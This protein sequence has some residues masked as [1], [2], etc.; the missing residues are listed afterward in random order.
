M[1]FSTRQ[2]RSQSPRSSWSAPTNER[3]QVHCVWLKKTIALPEVNIQFQISSTIRIAQHKY[4][5]PPPTATPAST[6]SFSLGVLASNC[7]GQAHPQE[8]FGLAHAIACHTRITKISTLFYTLFWIFSLLREPLD[9]PLPWKI[10]YFMS[11]HTLIPG[12]QNKQR[13]HVS[14]CA[15]F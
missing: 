10:G 8:H 1:L 14:G 2:S 3:L 4:L 6:R 7:P 15:R 9:I 11:Y 13:K 12:D 5:L